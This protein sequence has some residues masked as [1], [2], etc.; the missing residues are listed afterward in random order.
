MEGLEHN[1]DMATAKPRQLVLAHGGDGLAQNGD[2]ALIGPL[3]PRHAHQQRGFAGARR[4]DQPDG[5]AACDVEREAFENM[6]TARPRP[7]REI[8]ALK[9]QG[10]F[11]LGLVHIHAFCGV[12]PIVV[13][14]GFVL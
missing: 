10:F 11:G 4:A 7:Q 12:K 13:A 8:D 1:T 14:G 2:D 5:F 6:H 9:D 3:Q